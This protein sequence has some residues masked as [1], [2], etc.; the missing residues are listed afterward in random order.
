M[1]RETVEVKGYVQADG[2]L[3]LDRKLDLPA[4]PVQVTVRPASMSDGPNL[5]RFQALMEQIWAG[6]KARGHKPRERE[7]IDAEIQALQE[8]AEQELQDAERL[9]DAMLRLR[10]RTE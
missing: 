9:H 1:S 6:Q 3:R 8:E 4:G 7:Q 5:A 10:A 2:T